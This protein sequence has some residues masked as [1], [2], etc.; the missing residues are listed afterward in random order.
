M[1]PEVEE[2]IDV[3]RFPFFTTLMGKGSVNEHKPGFGGVYVGAGTKPD[4]KQVVESADCVLRIGNYLV[5]SK[6]I[7]VAMD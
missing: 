6:P 2:L 5:S 4:V 1:L 7:C 3:T